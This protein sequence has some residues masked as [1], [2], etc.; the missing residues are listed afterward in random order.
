MT[1]RYTI[2]SEEKQYLDILKR[3]AVISNTPIEKL[4]RD[5]WGYACDDAL[6]DIP[7]SDIK[8]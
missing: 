7:Y 6:A 5:Y 1:K 3:L 8:L 2:S 4:L